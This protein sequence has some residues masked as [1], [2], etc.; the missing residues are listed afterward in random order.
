M[1]LRSFTIQRADEAKPVVEAGDDLWSEMGHPSVWLHVPS[2]DSNRLSTLEPESEEYALLLNKVIRAN[3]AEQARLLTLLEKFYINHT[4]MS[5]YSRLVVETIDLGESCLKPQ[6]ATIRPILDSEMQQ[7]Q[8]DESEV[9]LAAFSEFLV[10]Q[11]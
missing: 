3:L 11:L 8:N 9:E 7:R 10:N 1:R 5:F 6:G 2:N 4:S